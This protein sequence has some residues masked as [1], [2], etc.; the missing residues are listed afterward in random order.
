MPQAGIEAIKAGRMFAVGIGVEVRT[1]R[2]DLELTSTAELTLGTN[3]KRREEMNRKTYWKGLVLGGGSYGI[4][5][6]NAGAGQP[7]GGHGNVNRG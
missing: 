6:R 5:M 7:G 3:C 4:I 2:P 1:V